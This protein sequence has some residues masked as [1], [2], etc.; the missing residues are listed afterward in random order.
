MPGA[1]D[2][3]LKEQSP[4]GLKLSPEGALFSQTGVFSAGA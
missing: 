2:T 1:E 4:D 3:G